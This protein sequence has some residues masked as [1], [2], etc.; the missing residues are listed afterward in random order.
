M[1]NKNLLKSVSEYVYGLFREKL[2]HEYVYHDYNH[3]LGVVDGCKE[4]GEGVKLAE[5][6]ME[7]VII[8]AWFHDTGYIFSYAD[9][10]ERSAEIAENFLKE[11]N[12]PQNKID[13]IK[14]CI[15]STKLPQKPKNIVEEVI[16]DAEFIH[17]GKK[18]FFNRINLLR[19]EWEKTKNK[20]VNDFEWYKENID[21]VIDHPF[22]TKFAQ[23][24]FEK[25][26]SENLSRLQK[27]LRKQ[28]L[29]SEEWSAK[30]SIQ[31]EKLDL[32]KTKLSK[33]ERGIETMFRITSRNHIELS[34]MAD[35]KAN[36]MISIN[37]I[38]ISIIVSVM[39]RKLD[40][41]P[42]LTI[43]TFMLLATSLA[44]IILATIVTR[45]KV[46]SGTF[47]PDDIKDKKANLLFFG[48]FYNMKMDDFEWGMKEMMGDK[49]YLYQSLIRDFHSLGIVL[50]KKY[51][52]L[53]L[54]Y[55]VFMYGMILTVAAYVIAFIL[56][57]ELQGPGSGIDFLIE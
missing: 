52:Y 36:I 13:E 26:R 50:G 5:S 29:D 8:A 33:P 41:N 48:N 39:I 45:P 55:N 23:R 51:K 21:F 54:C 28:M 9:H 14:S 17:F 46:T 10:E 1:N 15:L 44:S 18:E 53:N 20:I 22:H 42:A 27:K 4:I 2:P 43:P 6:E 47:T 3:T 31:K 16:C 32:T 37:T 57:P 12:Y 30:F 24:E 11:H 7:I 38:I 25:Q 56:S 35:N 49:E 40:A 19:V 34:G